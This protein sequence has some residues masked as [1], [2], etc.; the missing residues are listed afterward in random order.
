LAAALEALDVLTLDRR[1]FA[2]YRTS[3]GAGFSLV[4]EL[5]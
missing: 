5:V 4:L 1:G 3:S 2:T